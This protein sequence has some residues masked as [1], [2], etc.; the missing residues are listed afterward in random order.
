[1]QHTCIPT[2]NR[3]SWLKAFWLFAGLICLPLVIQASGAE[4]LDSLR[5]LIAQK[6]VD[7]T[8]VN[9][10]REMMKQ[11]FPEQQDSA[12]LFAEQASQLSDELHWLRGSRRVQEL[13]G[14]LWR[15]KSQ[16]GPALEAYQKAL[17]L[18]EEEGNYRAKAFN[19]SFIGFVHFS[20]E[21]YTTSL[22]YYRQSLLISRKKGYEGNYMRQNNNLGTVYLRQGLMDSAIH[23]FEKSYQLAEKL[24]QEYSMTLI[25]VNLANCYVYSGKV[26]NGRAILDKAIETLKKSNNSAMLGQAYGN[27][28]FWYLQQVKNASDDQTY[29]ERYLLATSIEAFHKAVRIHKESKQYE[30]LK[31]WYL[32]LRD[33]YVLEQNTDSAIYYYDQLQ[34]VRDTLFNLEKQKQIAQLEAVRAAALKDAQIQVLKQEKAYEGLWR[35]SLTVAIVL[36]ILVI[37]FLIMWMGAQ[38]KRARQAQENALLREQQLQENLDLRNRQLTS[39]ALQILQKNSLME[40]LKAD[41]KQLRGR[42]APEQG[43]DLN[44]LMNRLSQGLQLDQDWDKF[45]VYFE[46]VH[47]RFFK[48]LTEGREALTTSEQ[49]HAA[50]VKLGMSLKESASILSIEPGSV[51]IARNRLKKKLG[52]SAEDDLN[53]FLKSID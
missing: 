10:L 11:Y 6:T 47:P 18:A 4:S 42:S 44:N 50:M 12:L 31:H 39:H 43:K 40:E 9:A 26:E 3:P 28:G 53:S 52:L 15:E 23:Y 24:E 13:L 48:Q 34:A 51:K 14:G 25:S 20:L 36:S 2:L 33:A 5:K 21:D 8:Q 22:Q 46:E 1:M 32:N 35:K 41:I 27:L 7:S 29:P 45:K 17:S 37:V 49:R 19:L 16:F 30:L 38:R